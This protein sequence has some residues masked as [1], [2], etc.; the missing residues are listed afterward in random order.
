[1][2]ALWRFGWVEQSI[3][4]KNS[5]RFNSTT[6]KLTVSREVAVINLVS[7]V[8]NGSLKMLFLMDLIS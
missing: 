6:C 4:I 7:R 5:S 1:M 8:A 2:A 3:N